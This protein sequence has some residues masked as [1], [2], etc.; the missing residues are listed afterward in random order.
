LSPAAMED[1]IRLL[2]GRQSG[3]VHAEKFGDILDTRRECVEELREVGRE[4]TVGLPP[5][6]RVPLCDSPPSR[7]ALR[8]APFA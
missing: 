2:N 1:A 4:K 6:A 3:V 8:W 5:V 7:F